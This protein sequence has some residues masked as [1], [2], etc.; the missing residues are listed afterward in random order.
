VFPASGTNQPRLNLESSKPASDGSAWDSVI[1]TSE[2]ALS[3]GDHVQGTAY[4][5]C[6]TAAN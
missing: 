1:V 5:V 4:A 2:G 3:D 6:V